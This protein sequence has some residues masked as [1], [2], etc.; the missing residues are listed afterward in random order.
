MLLKCLPKRMIMSDFKELRQ[1]IEFVY[2]NKIKHIKN[3]LFSEEGKMLELYE[4]IASGKF[5]S[6][7]VAKRYFY[8][9]GGNQDSYFNRLKRNLQNRLADMILLIDYSNSPYEN[10]NTGYIY[11]A[12]KLAVI[13][14]WAYFGRP[15]SGIISLAEKTIRIA[16]YHGFAEIIFFV[17]RYCYYYYQGQNKYD[18]ASYYESLV[19]TY[20]EIVRLEAKIDIIQNKILQLNKKT[21]KSLS[22]EKEAFLRL[23]EKQIIEMRENYSSYRLN[24]IG[25][26]TLILLYNTLKDTKSVIRLFGEVIQDAKNNP[27]KYPVIHLNVFY[28][29][30]IEQFTK[31]E[32]YEKAEILYRERKEFFQEGGGNYSAVLKIM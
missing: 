3:V 17:S 29:E 25:V 6:E 9:K 13:N 7:V 1:M 2:P 10:P 5:D 31:I 19:D 24:T 27:H 30:A 28:G 20:S 23:S 32:N 26:L 18:K 4:G 16:K 15:L 14:I 12:K 21:A 8:P 22:S 11:C